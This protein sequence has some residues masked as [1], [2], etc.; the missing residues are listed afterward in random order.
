MPYDRTE[1]D[2]IIKKIADARKRGRKPKL[3]RYEALVIEQYLDEQH[4]CGGVTNA[5]QKSRS[6]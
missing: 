1:A 6:K 3:S 5:I 4:W 2:R